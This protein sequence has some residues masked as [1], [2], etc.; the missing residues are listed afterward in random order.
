MLNVLLNVCP[1]F[2]GPESKL[3]VVLVILVT[4][5]DTLS[6]FVQVTLVPLGTLMIAGLYPVLVI[7]TAFTVATVADTV[8]V[9]IT[10]DSLGVPPVGWTVAL[11]FVGGL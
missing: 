6:M 9:P 8:A 4:V 3:R 10:V 2:I 1:L 5:C 11:G 7:L